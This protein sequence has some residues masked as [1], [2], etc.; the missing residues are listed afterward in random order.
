MVH[1]S[2]TYASI[3]KITR[4]GVSAAPTG[5]L[6]LIEQRFQFFHDLRLIEIE[7]F[8]LAGIGFE[9]VEL[10]GRAAQCRGG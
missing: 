10:A 2:I 6:G 7:V 3:S 9:V 5:R 4:R 1:G 8:G